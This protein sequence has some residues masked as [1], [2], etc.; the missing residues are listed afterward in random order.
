MARIT[1]VLTVNGRKVNR[2]TIKDT[3]AITEKIMKRF[4]EHCDSHNGVVCSACQVA[5]CMDEI[6]DA[7][8]V[9]A[10]PMLKKRCKALEQLLDW[11]IDCGFGFDNV[12]D[13]Y[14][15]Y[16]I[17][18]DERKSYT[19][20]MIQ[21]AELFLEDK[22]KKQKEGYSDGKEPDQKPLRQV[23]QSKGHPSEW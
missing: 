1:I 14:E 17:K 21:F 11:A 7:P 2:M 19:E 5:D 23:S 16:G 3:D 12:R 8:T 13:V 6:D 22:E 15:T 9:D 10:V 20:Q 4:C 18:L